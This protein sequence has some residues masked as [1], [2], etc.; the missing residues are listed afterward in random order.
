MEPRDSVAVD[1]VGGDEGLLGN[2]TG[3][4]KVTGAADDWGIFDGV[5]GNVDAEQAEGAIVVG[6]GEG[7]GLDK[8]EGEDGLASIA[9]PALDVA[10]VEGVVEGGGAGEGVV[11]GVD[12]PEGK[13]LVLVGRGGQNGG[14]GG[15]VVHK[16][17]VL[18]GDVHIELNV[19]GLRG[20][21]ALLHQY[22]R[23]R[24]RKRHRQSCH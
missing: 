4:G 9:I 3:E 18:D 5:G 21:R 7:E 8:E 19:G 1:N 20:G 15:R 23:Y 11:E 12:I 24:E 6:G 14:I 22:A 2:S 10:N 17:S 16:A 13:G